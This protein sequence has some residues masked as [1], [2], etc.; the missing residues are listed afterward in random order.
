VKI[1][2]FDWDDGNWPKCG[3]HGLSQAEIEEVFRSGPRIHPDAAH[4]AKEVRSLADRLDHGRP[5]VLAAFTL[6]RRG[7]ED[8]IRPISALHASQGGSAL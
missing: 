6:R 1:S 7:E 4:S 5:V 2:G 8:L 3:R